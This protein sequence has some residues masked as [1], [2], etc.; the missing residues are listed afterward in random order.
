L[1]TLTR[2]LNKT[3]PGKLSNHAL[4]VLGGLP[5]KRTNQA[6]AEKQ[7]TVREQ[8]CHKAR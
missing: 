1:G 7:A 5:G 3:I 6:V 8:A 4:A 2:R